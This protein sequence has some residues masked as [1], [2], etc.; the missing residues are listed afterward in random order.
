MVEGGSGDYRKTVRAELLESTGGA[1]FCRTGLVLSMILAAAGRAVLILQG[2]DQQVTAALLV[3]CRQESED[4]T[5]TQ[6]NSEAV[7]RE[8]KSRDDWDKSSRK[9]PT[10][11]IERYWK[12]LK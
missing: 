3:L 4:W 10:R 2:A 9:V 1:G 7:K 6:R 5:P 8:R 11:R 12:D